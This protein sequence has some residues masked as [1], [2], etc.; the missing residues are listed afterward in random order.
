VRDFISIERGDQFISMERVVITGMGVITPSGHGLE[1]FWQ[2]ITSGVSAVDLMT[3]YDLSEY[4][5]RIAAQVHNFDPQKYLDRKDIRHMD[6]FV[7]LAI[8]A[9]QDAWD[10]AKIADQVDPTR[11]GVIV[12]NGIGGMHTLT[13]QHA[14]LLERGPSR[15]TPYFIPKM[16]SNIAGG[17]LA[18]RFNLLGPNETV[19]TACASSGNAIGEGLRIIQHGEADVM[20]VG[21]TEA[22]LIPL[23]FA[24]FCA[25]KATSTRNDDPRHASRPFDRDRD[26]F[27]MGEGAGFLVLERLDHAERRGARI[28][29]ELAGYGRSSDAYH[30]V[31]PH[32]EGIGAGLA[33]QR[34]LADAGLVPSEIDYIN[35][36]ATSTPK[37]DIAETM[38]IKR[39]FG[40]HAYRLAVSSTKS[41]TGHLLGAAGAVEFIASILALQRQTVPPT[42]NLENPD[43]ECDLYY[44]PNRPEPRRLRAVMS[45][46]FGFGGQNAS[47]IAREI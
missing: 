5:T 18:I 27:V 45:N 17:Q 43:P 38:A 39:V 32:P 20:L 15:V 23:A 11:A 16:I 41:S 31:E 1:E 28:Y 34:A 44:V 4:P 33:M 24:G 35:A 30:V 40:D 19:V 42:I 29:A 21:G 26:G 25:M 36:H 7:Q 22:A 37:G 2:G 46:A 8:G 10:D 14:V 3:E 47:L 12:G 6:R 9:A 13:E